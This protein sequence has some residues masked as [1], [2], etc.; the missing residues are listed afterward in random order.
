MDC[1]TPKKVKYPSEKA[2]IKA[3]QSMPRGASA[4]N[5]PYRCD[6]HWHVGRITKY[7]LR[8]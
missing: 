1:R 4:G 3:L 8:K 6:G 7:T 2:A 5:L